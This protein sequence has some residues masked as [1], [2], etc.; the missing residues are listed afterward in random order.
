MPEPNFLDFSA[1][2]GLKLYA[3]RFPSLKEGLPKA[4][5]ILFHGFGAYTN[6]YGYVAEVFAQQ[7][8][9]FVGFDHRGF[10]L[11]EGERGLIPSAEEHLED[12]RRFVD[13]VKAFYTAK[14]GKF[15]P[16]VSMG[17]SLGG[18][19]SLGVWRTHED[20]ELFKA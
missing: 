4:V 13:L 12:S 20:K 2:N 15:P 10:G 17:Y 8:Y 18:C 11:S 14:F 5:V 7:G 16:L 19:T 9:D 1:S 6:K 3:G